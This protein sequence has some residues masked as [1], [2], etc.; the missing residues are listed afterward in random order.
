MSRVLSVSPS[1]KSKV[2]LGGL[3]TALRRYYVRGT[4]Y[5]V[6]GVRRT[7]SQNDRDVTFPDRVNKEK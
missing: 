7:P 1:L 5:G 4:Y 2:F 6:L 3:L